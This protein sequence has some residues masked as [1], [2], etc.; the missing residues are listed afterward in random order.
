MPAVDAPTLT[1]Y[2][3]AIQWGYQ[4]P[5]VPIM[6]WDD[7]G[8]SQVQ[9]GT[10]PGPR[11]S[12][13]L[14]AA[15]PSGLTIPGAEWSPQFSTWYWTD[16]P[17]NLTARPLS[18]R[19]AQDAGNLQ[20]LWDAAY[21]AWASKPHNAL[22][23]DWYFAD[24][25]LD[26]PPAQVW[27]STVTNPDG[28]QGAYVP[29]PAGGYVQV[30]GTNWWVYPARRV[31]ALTPAQTAQAVGHPVAAGQGA[32]V[33]ADMLGPG[34][35]LTPQAAQFVLSTQPQAVQS[36]PKAGALAAILKYA[37]PALAVAGGVAALAATGVLGAAMAATGAATVD[38]AAPVA[39]AVGDVLPGATVGVQAAD[40]IPG[41]TVIADATAAPAGAPLATL[42]ADVPA[43][44][45]IPAPVLAT[46]GDVA[47]DAL[48]VTTPDQ[49]LAGAQVVA[50]AG[51]VAP[52]AG[53]TAAT[54]DI[55]GGAESAGGGGAEAA[56]G[57]GGTTAAQPSGPL[58]RLLTSVGLDASTAQDVAD[59]VSVANTAASVG[60]TIQ[61]FASGTPAVAAQV[62]VGGTVRETTLAP[63]RLTA[64]AAL[65]FPLTLPDGTTIPAGTTLP[66][67]TAIPPG[68]VMDSGPT[69][70]QLGTGGVLLL[71][72]GLG[73]LLLGRR[74]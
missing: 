10:T 56:A 35:T 7:L 68:T 29:A 33:Y 59:A 61:H 70:G 12:V 17:G 24:V 28:T 55:T 25:A 16:G 31:V 30:P 57:G 14:Q 38:T 72:A 13:A 37:A 65:P 40:V 63:A 48:V 53:V 42:P 34:G 43:A 47:P 41:A 6:G 62:G 60:Q 66:P 11:I 44:V 27:D 58:A 67:G 15:D 22:G 3:G 9:V 21:P 5:D 54:A 20:A 23:Q 8:V 50:N 19:D 36:A 39:A 64:P 45:E 71:A 69:P 52:D 2:G 1:F 74:R 26:G 32:F 4:G 49:V 46:A 73:L 51:D 18:A